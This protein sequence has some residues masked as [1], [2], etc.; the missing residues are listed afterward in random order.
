MK[1][2]DKTEIRQAQEAS[3]R[4]LIYVPQATSPVEPIVTR[5]AKARQRIMRHIIGIASLELDH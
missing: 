1:G 4:R 5:Q 3:T 2:Q